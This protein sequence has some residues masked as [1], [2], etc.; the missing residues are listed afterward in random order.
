MGDVETALKKIA[1]RERDRGRLFAALD[2]LLPAIDK[3]LDESDF[4]GNIDSRFEFAGLMSDDM[5]EHW[6]SIE[7]YVRTQP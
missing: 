3:I 2:A 1:Y 7:E 6:I 5:I 4:I